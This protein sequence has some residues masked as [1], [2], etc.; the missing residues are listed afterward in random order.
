MKRIKSA[1]ANLAEMSNR[2]KQVSIIERPGK[3]VQ[4]GVY[5]INVNNFC[6][7]ILDFNSR[8]NKDTTTNKDSTSTRYSRQARHHVI[9]ITNNKNKPYYN[10]NLGQVKKVKQQLKIVSNYILDVAQDHN[11]KLTLEEYIIFSGILEYFTENI[12]KKITYDKILNY[13]IVYIVKYFINLYLISHNIND[14]IDSIM[15]ITHIKDVI[16]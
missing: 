10:V 16:A 15:L 13:L 14:S 6:N 8:H 3:K 11:L 7:T 2:K 4:Q 1:P 12:Y 9:N 5:V